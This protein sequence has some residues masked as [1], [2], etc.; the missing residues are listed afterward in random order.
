MNDDLLLQYLME[1]G[2]LQPEDARIE[3]LRAQAQ[4]LRG[5]PYPDLPQQGRIAVRQPR[6]AMIA[7]IVG[8][9][10]GMVGDYKA[11][12]AGA[13]QRGRRDASFQRLMALRG[14]QRNP[15]PT[16]PPG[17]GLEDDMTGLE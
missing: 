7:P 9:L 12:K 13:A 5:T 8:A 14:G 2:D 4:A 1:Q 15:F 11:D 3:K 10:G 17:Y 16:R 6:N